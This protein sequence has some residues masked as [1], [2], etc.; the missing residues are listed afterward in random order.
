M[1]H[2]IFAAL[3]LACALLQIGCGGTQADD[4]SGSSADEKVVTT[5]SGLQYVEV[6]EGTGDEARSGKMVEVFYTGWLKS[7]KKF[8]SNVGGK[9]LGFRLG[10]GNVIKG[11]DEG[12]TGM[13]VGGKRKL[14][15]PAKLGYGERGAGGV[16]PPNSDLIFEVE[17]VK[18]F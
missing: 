6:K 18:V 8:D 2:C 7:G 16:I 5:K 14:L 10:E 9:P 17:L 15:I 4:K 1:Q 12:V 3:L 13:K 11:Y